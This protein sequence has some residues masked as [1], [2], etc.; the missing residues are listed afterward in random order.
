QRLETG[1]F[2]TQLTAIVAP[3]IDR[4]RVRFIEGDACKL[5]ASGLNKGQG[6]YDAVLLSNLLCRLPEPAACLR[7]FV[8]NDDYLGREGILVIA[9]PNTWLSQYTPVERF[10]DGENSEATLARI[11]AV[12]EGFELLHEEDFPFMIREHRRKYEYIVSQISV[13]RK[14]R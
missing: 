6:P 11:A 12:L 4:N 1:S 10:L 9:S 2:Q 5:G 7:Q 14:R 13:W 3:D 8:H